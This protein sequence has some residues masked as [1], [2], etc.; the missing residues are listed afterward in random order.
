[1][2]RPAAAHPLLAYIVPYVVYAV[3]QIFHVALPDALNAGWPGM[4]AALG[5]ACAVVALIPALNRLHIS[6]Q[7]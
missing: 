2:L 1:M 6:L 5:Y 4:L 7:L 3:M